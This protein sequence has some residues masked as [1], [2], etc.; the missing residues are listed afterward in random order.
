MTTTGIFCRL[1][2]PVLKRK[3]E[4]AAFCES[5]ATCT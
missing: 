1:T 3:G 2:C 5:I 4:N